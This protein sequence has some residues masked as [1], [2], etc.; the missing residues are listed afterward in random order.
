MRIYSDRF[1][2]LEFIPGLS[3][4]KQWNEREY[5]IMTGLKAKANYRSNVVE[6]FR[7]GSR[8]PGERYRLEGEK[9]PEYQT[10]VNESDMTAYLKENPWVSAFIMT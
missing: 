7:P 5:R 10:E 6:E 9:L 1:Y 3:G 4:F 2:L 8:G